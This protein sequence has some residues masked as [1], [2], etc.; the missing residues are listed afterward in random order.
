MAESSARALTPDAAAN[1]IA[2]RDHAVAACDAV[3]QHCGRTL[4]L[5]EDP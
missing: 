3:R 5:L 4:A 2:P 1:V